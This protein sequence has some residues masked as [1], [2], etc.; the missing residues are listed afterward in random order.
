MLVA[1]TSAWVE[2]L[3]G[4]DS[5]ARH[6]LRAALAEQRVFLVEPVRAE[7]LA[8]ARSD[9]ERSKLIRMFAGVE[10]APVAPS[11]DFDGAAGL[12]FRCR[13]AGITPRNLMDCLI[14]VMA[15]R[16]GLA[17]LHHDRDFH[18]IASILGI[19]QASGS[20]GS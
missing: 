3:R 2:F 12:Y 17:V 6:S 13:Q 18:Q 1:D 4:A 11:D 19:T 10:C 20:L 14:A 5:P 15:H 9:S 7:V 8:G 16:L